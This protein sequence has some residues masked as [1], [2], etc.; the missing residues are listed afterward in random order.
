MATQSLHKI[1]FNGVLLPDIFF[2]Y[3]DAKQ[4]LKTLIESSCAGQGRVVR[5][6]DETGEIM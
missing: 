1:I 2:T 3:D 5:Y 6:D 4:R